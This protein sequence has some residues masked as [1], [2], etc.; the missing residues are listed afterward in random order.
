MPISDARAGEISLTNLRNQTRDLL[1]A[2]ALSPRG[3]EKDAALTALCDLY[4]V[5]RKDA[6]FDDSEMLQQDA[7]KIR[8]RLLTSANR[9]AGRLKRAKVERPADLDRAVEQAVSNALENPGDYMGELRNSDRP[10]SGCPNT[11]RSAQGRGAGGTA[12]NGW[13]LVELIQRIIA[14]DFWDVNGGSGT[15]HYFAM[16]RVLVVSATSD[17]HEQIRDLLMSLPR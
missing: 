7:G 9:R 6:R 8:R 4:V 17:V 5:L 12:D 10:N 15:I 1:R 16:R 3:A 11:D 13:Q 2:E 14:P